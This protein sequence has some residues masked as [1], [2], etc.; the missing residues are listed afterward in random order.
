VNVVHLGRAPQFGRA[1]IQNAHGIF[2][3]RIKR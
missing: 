2:S 3:T 1:P